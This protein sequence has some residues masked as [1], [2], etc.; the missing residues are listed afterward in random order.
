MTLNLKEAPRKVRICVPICVSAIDAVRQVVAGLTGI[1]DLVELRLDYL[2]P[3]EFENSRGQDELRRLLNEVAT[4]VILTFRPGEQGGRRALDYASRY[5]FWNLEQS[6]QIAQF[7]DIEL[8]LAL[9]FISSRSAPPMPIDWNR[10]ICSH[11]DFIGVP[12]NLDDIYKRMASTPARILKLAL[13]ADDVTDCIPIF[14]L[15]ARARSENREMIAIAMGPAGIATRILGPSRGAFL[16]YAA[17]DE[18][19]ANA[20]GQ[21]TVDELRTLYRIYKIDRETQIMGLV[22]LPV[23]HSLSPQMHNAAFESAGVNAVYIPFPVR[24]IASF[25]RR[26]IHPHTR[27]IDWNIR[28]L[29]VTAP[30]KNAV[31]TCL[32]RIDR[33]AMEIGAVN[34]IV[35]EEDGLHGYNTDAEAFIQ[36][37]SPEFGELRDARCALIGSGGAASAVL[38]GL[39]QA[40]AEVTVFARDKNKAAALGQRFQVPSQPLAEASFGEF[41]LVVNATPLGTSGPLEGE[42]PATADQLRGARLACDLVYNPQETR[43]LREARAAGCKTLG[44]MPMLVR[45]AA[46]Q[47]SLWT[48]IPAPEKVMLQVAIEALEKD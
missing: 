20:P 43:F 9:G 36:T 13:Q 18:K 32:D 14:K 7:H 41:D 2:L 21:L 38:W 35:V 17:L 25:M 39:R 3:T 8:D 42:T 37:I 4:P 26:M 24:D 1:A 28:G 11:H 40:G 44:G 48:K 23:T 31:M 46:E 29:S 27:E 47:F 10:I 16:T 15:L 19:S 30:H 45:Q 33:A 6:S 12:S 22:G 5:V 34:T